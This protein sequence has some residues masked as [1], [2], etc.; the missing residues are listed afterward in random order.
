[1]KQYKILHKRRGSLLLDLCIFSVIL[2]IL[3]FPLLPSGGTTVRT[4]TDNLIKDQALAVDNALHVWY[5]SHGGKFPSTLTVLQDMNFISTEINLSVFS[6][7]LQS[8][9]TEYRLTTTLN[10]GTTYKSLGSHY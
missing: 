6:Y 7:S 3:L 1:M 8:S 10:N 5:S 4:A 9:Q 2:I